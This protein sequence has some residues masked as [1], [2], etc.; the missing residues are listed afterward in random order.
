[1]PTCCWALNLRNFRKIIVPKP[2]KT[3]AGIASMKIML[4]MYA[5]GNRSSSAIDWLHI[6]QAWAAA[7]NSDRPHKAAHTNDK[8]LIP[9]RIVESLSH[10]PSVATDTNPKHQRGGRAIPLLA[11][12]V[13]VRASGRG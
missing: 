2:V 7:A 12:R 3:V 9:R 5:C 6:G 13:S 1:M 8:S 10:S 4:Y 11:R